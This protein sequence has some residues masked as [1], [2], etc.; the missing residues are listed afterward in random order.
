[1]ASASFI[2]DFTVFTERWLLKSRTSVSYS[3]KVYVVILT[4]PALSSTFGW[5]FGCHTFWS[6]SPGSSGRR[7]SWW[8]S[9]RWRWPWR[10]RPGRGSSL[11]RAQQTLPFHP[12]APCRRKY[13]MSRILKNIRFQDFWNLQQ[14]LQEPGWRAPRSWWS[15]AH[16][17]K[18]LIKIFKQN[19]CSRI[20][21]QLWWQSLHTD[22]FLGN[23][24]LQ[25]C[26][27]MQCNWCDTLWSWQLQALP[28]QLALFQVPRPDEYRHHHWHQLIGS[29][30]CQHVFT[31]QGY[32]LS[33][34]YFFVAPVGKSNRPPSPHIPEIG[35]PATNLFCEKK[36]RRR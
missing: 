13:E 2:L 4:I 33:S 10:G 28:H 17:C 11:G 32:F 21:G 6:C 34:F 16:T 36:T 9:R 19:F 14:T 3:R 30:S 8:G 27:L 31:V 1:M 12:P 5:G 26:S 15:L 29:C 35:C 18:N 20:P 7:G 24:L 22:L 23:D 25:P